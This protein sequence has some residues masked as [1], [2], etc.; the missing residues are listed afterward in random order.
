MQERGA[1]HNCGWQW[2]LVKVVV[3]RVVMVALLLPAGL[4]A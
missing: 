3:V 1:V 4:Y 2:S